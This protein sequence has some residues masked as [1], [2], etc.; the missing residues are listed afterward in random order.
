MHTH[1]HAQR[2]YE[3]SN[4][5]YLFPVLVV[6]PKRRKQFPRSA[7]FTQT[8]C[9]RRFLSLLPH[10]TETP[11]TRGG[12]G[13]R[14]VANNN[15]ERRIGCDGKSATRSLG[16]HSSRTWMEA[17]TMEA[18][19]RWKKQNTKKR[20]I[21]HRCVCVCA[22]PVATNDENKLLAAS[23]TNVKVLQHNNSSQPTSQ[24][25]RDMPRQAEERGEPGFGWSVQTEGRS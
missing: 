5:N 1:T 14:K 16:R 18:F 9:L 17:T 13:G 20:C 10:R 8:A 15:T 11:P 19:K 21:I 6:H 7:V 4:L 24:A 23:C 25:E 3:I 2:S 22:P 12:E